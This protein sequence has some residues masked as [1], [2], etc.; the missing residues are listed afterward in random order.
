MRAKIQF[1]IGLS[2]FTPYIFLSLILFTRYLPILS[3]KHQE[4]HPFI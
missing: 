3:C 2:L 1:F 4:Q